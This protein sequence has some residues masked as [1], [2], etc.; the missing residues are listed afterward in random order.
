MKI[1]YN[2]LRSKITDK[3]NI[4]EYLQA[5][6]AINRAEATGTIPQI[7]GPI[8]CCISKVGHTSKPKEKSDVIMNKSR[9]SYIHL[10]GGNVLKDRWSIEEVKHYLENGHSIQ[11]GTY[12][13]PNESL[14]E[15]TW[16]FRGAQFKSANMIIIDVDDNNPT[17]D[18]LLEWSL[19]H[20]P[21]IIYETF[22]HTSENRRFR[23]IY[24]L[25]KSL[26]ALSIRLI[27]QY[28]MDKIKGS[29]KVC[30]DAGRLY[31]GGKG[32][33]YFE[34]NFVFSDEI[35]T[36][37]EVLE[38]KARILEEKDK[39]VKTRLGKEITESLSVSEQ[40][41]S[42]RLRKMAKNI[43]IDQIERMKAFDL[44]NALPMNELLNV[45]I[46]DT[47]RCIMPDHHDN[48]PS[49]SILEVGEKQMYKCFGCNGGRPK[50]FID[51]VREVTGKTIKDTMAFILQ[52]LDIEFDTT[53]RWNALQTIQF[54]RIMLSQN[55]DTAIYK[56]LKN[57]RLLGLY[58]A[59]TNYLENYL[60]ESP[61]EDRGISMFASM[62]HLSKTFRDWG[63]KGATPSSISR[64]MRD[65]SSYGLIEKVDY[66]DL[67]DALRRESEA[68]KVKQGTKYAVTYWRLPELT[69]EILEKALEKI[70]NEKSLG[71]TKRYLNRT[72]MMRTHGQEE[73]QK[74]YNQDEVLMYSGNVNA[75][76]MY[77]VRAFLERQGY[78]TRQELID[79][80][81]YSE[82]KVYQ[83]LP[84]IAKELGLVCKRINKELKEKFGIDLPR[85]SMV[86]VPE[87]FQEI[88]FEAVSDSHYEIVKQDNKSVSKECFE[89]DDSDIPF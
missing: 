52:N 14:G 49:S 10:P 1:D 84:G 5:H 20:K 58:I 74:V 16:T 71:Y 75:E 36:L 76:V 68:I 62:T 2:E 77:L 24:L 83:Y 12:R 69:N 37:P 38:N 41:L 27:T 53:Y 46:G 54:N 11:N 88:E 8:N 78:F 70:E 7:A 47:F 50:N 43:K 86:Y 61:I 18:N 44:I 21:C 17:I 79:H 34:G 30:K 23:I 60:P 39:T 28:F 15:K 67:P 25:D 33:P 82:K 65:L 87:N 64:K 51:V 66:K 85:G 59:F 35:L 19:P 42:E 80:T 29:D 32:V 9:F 4:K 6:A 56:K 81:K 22:S 55:Q 48:N 73:T 57:A 31:Y 3:G 26:T 63:I 89:C 40:Q 13:D 45:N 72:Q